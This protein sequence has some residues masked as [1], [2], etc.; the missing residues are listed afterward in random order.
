MVKRVINF[1]IS[2]LATLLVILGLLMIFLPGPAIIILPLGILLFNKVQPG[3]IDPYLRA[4]MRFMSRAGKSLDS[5]F[6][7]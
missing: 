6:K 3:K 7:R 1:G 4:F 2:V 5:L